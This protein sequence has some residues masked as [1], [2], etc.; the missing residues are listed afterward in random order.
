[1]ISRH[2]VEE[3]QE[4]LDEL[5]RLRKKEEEKYGELLTLLDGKCGFPLP[6]EVS[7]QL[8][9]IKDALN[10]TWDIGPAA[11]SQAQS[12]DR[13]FWKEV[14]A[15]TGRY[16][17]PF[18]QQQSEFNSL[19]VHLVN[20]FV[21]SVIQSLGQIREFQN[22]LILYLQSIVPVV[23]TKFRE[24]VG[25]EDKN[26]VTNLLKFQKQIHDAARDHADLL[27]QELDKRMGTLQVD[28]G[29]QT[30]AIRSLQ[31]SLRSLHHLADAL[32]SSKGGHE[33]AVP[34]DEYRYYHFEENFRGTREQIREKFQEYVPHFSK[35]L[36]GPV[37]DLGCGRGE[38]LE[39]L[40][41]AGVAALGVDSNA[42]MVKKCKDMGLDVHTGD[43]FEFLR[44]RKENSLGGIFCSQVVE[45]LPPDYLLKLLDAAYARLQEGAPILLETVNIS[46]AFAFLQVYTKDLT[47]RTP[48]HPDTLKF[49]VNASGFRDPRILF[50]S[51][52]PAPAQLKL[53][54]QPAD[55]M[56]SVFN[57]NMEKLN[58][59]LF[60][61]QE[62]AVLAFK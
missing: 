12:E 11:L 46:S 23:D 51:P 60:D 6:Q 22:T 26:I 4:K 21:E 16:L 18:V 19:V 48:I 41:G 43:L 35:R 10:R 15:N 56:Q 31:I 5:I 58:R 17:Q 2:P 36:S 54:A 30:E 44:S 8:G 39:L 59:L 50:T 9:E 29:E 25:I 53:F 13:T 3:L 38:F 33:I 49:I 55:E 61:P 37:L 14:A 42:S 57:Q 32:K 24:M 7:R 52:V 45:H 34:N 27:Y 62:Y 47:H 20:E 1:M 28:S 40:R